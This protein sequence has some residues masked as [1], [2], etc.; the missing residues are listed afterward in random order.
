MIDWL[1]N[2][3]TALML[4][5]N[6]FHNSFMDTFM[7]LVSNK[8]MWVPMYVMIPYVLYK[9][10]GIK[11]ALFLVVAMF[12]INLF[13]TDSFC[14]QVLRHN[15]LRPRPSNA[16][17]PI[18]G[19]VHI[20]NGYR[21][22]HYGFPSCHAA[23]SFS[24]ATLITLVFQNRRTAVLM[25]LWAILHSYSRV[26]LGVHYPG[27]IIA[28]AIIGCMVAGLVYYIFRSVLKVERMRKCQ[29]AEPVIIPYMGLSILFLLILFCTINTYILPRAF[30]C[31]VN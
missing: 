19:M 28:G 13:A 31:H 9:R 15:I 10:F 16:D 24:L 2:I 20:V 21:G 12:F 5:L 3:D 29:T 18:F 7:W 30:V 26:Y 1:Q 25:F 17:S 27:D 14:S 8:L 23:N 6:G 11:A 22:G 4:W